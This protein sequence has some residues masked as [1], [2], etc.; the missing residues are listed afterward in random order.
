MTDQ[1]QLRDSRWND[2]QTALRDYEGVT[3]DDD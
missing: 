3:A 2:E 1:T